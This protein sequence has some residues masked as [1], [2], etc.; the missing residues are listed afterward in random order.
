MTAVSLAEAKAHLRVTFDT[1][2][3]YVTSLLE[4]AEG[5]V[6]EIGVAIATP[7]QAPIRHAIL[8]LVSHW[9]SNR[10]AAAEAPPRAIAYGVDA[11]VQPFRTQTI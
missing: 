1:D 10:D 11:L 3:D 9:Y 4:A 2:D 8:L 5:Y 6:T 7:V